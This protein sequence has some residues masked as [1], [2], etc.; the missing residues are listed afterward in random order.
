MNTVTASLRS[1]LVNSSWT[2]N[3]FVNAD[4]WPQDFTESCNDSLYKDGNDLA[5]TSMLTV[6][7]GHGFREGTKSGVQFGTARAGLCNVTF[8]SSRISNVGAARLGQMDYAKTGFST[9]ITSCSMDADL[10]D[11]GH[12]QPVAQSELPFR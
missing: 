4:A 6:Y 10:L 1:A 2:G 5:D 7:A 11:Q 12:Q 3:R 9:W 8:A